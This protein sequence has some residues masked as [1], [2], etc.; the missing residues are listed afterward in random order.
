MRTKILVLAASLLPTLALANGYDVPSVT[1]RD[2]ALVESGTA[3]QNDAGATY[4]NPAALSK[5]RGLSLNLA[6]SYLDLQ[7]SWSAPAGS[8]MAG[9]PDATTQK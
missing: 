5:V 9:S 7:T 4:A 6:G 8:V 1:P 2:L 3:A